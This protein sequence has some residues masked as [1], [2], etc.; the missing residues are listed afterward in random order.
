MPIADLLEGTIWTGESPWPGLARAVCIPIA[1]QAEIAGIPGYYAVPRARKKSDE[2]TFL[3][4]NLVLMG[5]R[6]GT[7]YGYDRDPVTRT[8][9]GVELEDHQLRSV[10]FVRQARGRNG[11][12]ILAAD[13]GLGK[14][15]SI[16][17]RICT[18]TGW[19]AIGN[20][21][22]G[23]SVFGSNGAPTAV[24]A[25]HPQG[26]KPSYRVHFSD[27]SS[28]EAGPEHLWT[29]AYRS[30]RRRPY[31]WKELTLTTR[32]LLERPILE[33]EG[34]NGQQYKL[35]LAKTDLYLPLLSAP[36]QYPETTESLPIGPYTLGQLIANGS[37]A[38]GS[39]CLVSNAADWPEIA[40]RLSDEGH[41][42]SSTRVYG[43]VIHA[44]IPGL[45]SAV[46]GLA[47]N[48]LSHAKRVPI[49][50]LRA[51]VEERQALLQGL[52]DGD[53]SISRECCR[54]VYHTT[55]EGLANDVLELIEG[56]GGI[57]RIHA[58][59]RGTADKQVEYQ[60]RLRLPFGQCPFGIKR[61]SARFKPGKNALPVR[62]V[63]CIEYVR[64]VESVCIS[65]DAVDRLYATE[66]CILT[67]NSIMSLQSLWLE[68]LLHSKGL[69][70]GP[71]S[72]REAWTG[73]NSDA[74]RHYRL[75]VC[76]LE[77]TSP[78]PA[79]I[80]RYNWFFIHY[81]ILHEWQS[82]LFRIFKPQ[83]MVFD[84]SHY[85]AN[86][87]AKRTKAALA[88][89]PA[90]TTQLRILLTG[91]PMPKY[92]MD[93]WAQLATAQ[94][95]QWGSKH[96]FGMRYCGG[97]KESYEQSKGHFV[98]D[99]QTCTE[100]LRAR[101]CGVY[102]RYTKTD[103]AGAL[104]PLVRERYAVP[105]GD[106]HALDAYWMAQTDAG[107]SLR[108]KRDVETVRIGGFEVPVG[109][110]ED[111]QRAVQLTCLNALISIL[112]MAKLP[113]VAEYLAARMHADAATMPADGLQMR[114][115]IV[116]TWQQEACIGMTQLLM[117]RAP[118]DCEIIG[119]VHGGAKPAKRQSAA[120]QFYST[121][122][123]AFFIC[124][125]SAM[126][127]ALNELRVADTVAQ[128]SPGW[129]PADN[130]QAESRGHRK[131]NPNPF[132]RSIYAIAQR[133]VDDL[134]LDKLNRKAQESLAV[135]D[136]DV[137]GM[138]LVG[139]ISPDGVVGKADD[140]DEICSVLMSAEGDE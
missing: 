83:A 36:L 23:D 55:S 21:R 49:R 123:K 61:K 71:M 90:V 138:H 81:E 34:L 79:I 133:T 16:D 15:H 31:R 28:V 53:G 108:K 95:N 44:T 35:D 78:D 125:R 91:T 140:L 86:P 92:R 56:L 66:H 80:S 134:F 120:E 25:V 51:A 29:V 9:S 101:L 18:P 39:P 70:C 2:G 1:K 26:V 59:N 33:Y 112:E 82:L 58:Y 75:E 97:H 89:S 117:A 5:R 93:L 48:V 118:G 124:T 103:V 4:H 20:L 6:P 3:P 32:Q 99:G 12:A 73:P 52:M 119:P 114:K 43:N 38:H 22:V 19:I 7:L 37:L 10:T 68:G 139:D 50:Y 74:R 72:A 94:P 137:H 106:S 24:T 62:T 116:F 121:A 105:F 17:T 131:G 8:P 54:V 132:V 46:K 115:V 122:S 102:L 87:D 76:P 40:T 27:G 65:V 104:P 85:L 128:V 41:R 57:G 127:T 77:S 45:V 63:G 109:G 136:A 42:P 96:T 11:G 69:I 67:H 113:F 13:P 64:D 47:L 110:A 84:E 60:V 130:I 14:Q 100:E 135:A 88:L 98:Y 111:K 30:S 126:G 129:N 107:Q